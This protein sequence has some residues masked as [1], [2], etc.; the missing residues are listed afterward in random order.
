MSPKS[1][2]VKHKASA[3]AKEPA[4]LDTILVIRLVIASVIF[5]VSLIVKMPTL[6]SIALLIVAAV[7]AGYDVILN[8]VN[9]VEKGDYF[10]TPVVVVFITVI[11]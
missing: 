10:A 1:D 6:V 3:P 5:A 2:H 4:A 9:S 7:A 11:S 8:A